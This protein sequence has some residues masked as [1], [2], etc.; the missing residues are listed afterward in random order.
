MREIYDA[1]ILGAG[2]NSLI[3]QAYLGRS[4]LSTICVEPRA[5]AG[6]G[7]ATV[8]HPSSSGFCHNIHSF[9]HRGL[10]R[11]PWYGDLNLRQHGAEYIEPELNV[12][13]ITQDGRA[14]QWWTQFEKTVESFAQFSR[15]D[16]NALR[17]WCDRFRPIVQ[18]ILVPEAQAPPLPLDQRRAILSETEEGRLLLKVSELSPL[19]FV[20]QE[21]EH[22]AIQSGLLF[23]NGLREVDLRCRG[24]GHHI[25]A[26]LASGRMAQ[27]C[28]GGSRRLADALVAAVREAGGEIALQTT[29]KRIQIED[30]HAV[31]VE[32]MEG[33]FIRARHLVASGLN[34]H[35]TFLDLIE[36]HQLPAA[37]AEKARSFQYNLIAPLFALNVNLR[38][39]PHYAAADRSPELKDAFMVI[40]GLDRPEQFE[41]IV[42]HHEAGSIPPTVMWGTCPTRFDASQAPP[43]GH[44]AFMWEK[45]PYRLEADPQ[46]WDRTK[47]EHGRALLRKWSEYA[48][49]LASAVLESFTASPLDVERTLPNMKH[50][51]LLVGAFNHG[52]V[53]FHRP[54][55]GAG[56]Y[57]GILKGLYLCGSCCHPGGNVTGLPGYNCA[58]VILTDLGIAAPWTPP[59]ITEQWKRNF[60]LTTNSH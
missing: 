14:L 27:M 5:V 57:R 47:E 52:Q 18:N 12:A 50:G 49:N 32:T 53:G 35:Q 43:G 13:L 11:L 55:A 24:F 9:Y 2:H 42:R 10:T 36:P 45:T 29:P 51:D 31:G 58:Q 59:P 3:L 60:V 25:P 34:P 6:G 39:A 26:L 1:V 40:L 30:G 21:F 54:F 8:E 48:P 28:V 17:R 44:T 20:R 22:P 23:F 33:A 7:L 38:E 56:H 16:A 19:E 46:N 15:R 4:G 41:D 37:V